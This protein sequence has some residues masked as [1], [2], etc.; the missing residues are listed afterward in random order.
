[1]FTMTKDQMKT[2]LKSAREAHLAWKEQL[3]K[4]VE[5]GKSELEPKL[6]RLDDQCELGKTLRD[7]FSPD[8]QMTSHFMAIKVLHADFHTAASEV[9]RMALAGEKGMAASLLEANGQYTRASSALVLAI[10]AWEED[11]V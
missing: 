3:L 5:S 7:S 8:V 9:L 6:V 10:K 1:M 11:F 2:C 4:A